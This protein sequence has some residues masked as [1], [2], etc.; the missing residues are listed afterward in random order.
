MHIKYMAVFLQTHYSLVT[1][2]ML[3]GIDFCHF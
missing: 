1:Y 2:V 3:R